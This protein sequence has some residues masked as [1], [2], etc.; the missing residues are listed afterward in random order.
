MCVCV[1]VC[2]FYTLTADQLIMGYLKSTSYSY[3]GFYWSLRDLKF[4]RFSRILLTILSDDNNDLIWIVSIHLPISKESYPTL[5]RLGTATRA[6]TTI[7]SPSS[8]SFTIYNSSD[9]V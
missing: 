9:K 8:S 2:S 7:L 4:P 1:C 5:H 3:I 6:P